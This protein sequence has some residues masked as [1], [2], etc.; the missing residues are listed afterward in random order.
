MAR[1]AAFQSRQSVTKQEL[2]SLVGLLS[3]ASKVVRPG[4]MFLRRLID[5]STTVNSLHHHIKLT[6]AARLDLGW[7][8]QFLHQWNGV[9]YIPRPPIS[10][11]DLELYTDASDLGLGCVYQ[12]FWIV[13]PWPPAWADTSINARE[14]FAIW[15]AVRVWGKGWFNSQI[16]VHTDSEVNTVTW[17]TGTCRDPDVM[18]V[19]RP[20]FLFAARHSINVTMLH[21]PG[22][23]NV[24][25]DCLSRF[26]VDE[27]R[28]KNPTATPLP[29]PIPPDV[30]TI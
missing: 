19:I 26:K 29:T 30:W 6:A 18:R 1:V 21:I 28:K 22:Y 20:M 3:F 10:S 2:L 7:W 9:G 4:R 14:A 16:V 13:A 11:P 25:A 12:N 23:K 8:H 24:L 27:F 17:K 5:L 15:V